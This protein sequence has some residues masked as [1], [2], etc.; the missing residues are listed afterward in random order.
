M[1]AELGKAE[2][3]LEKINTALSRITKGF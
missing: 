3:G 1:L 2:P